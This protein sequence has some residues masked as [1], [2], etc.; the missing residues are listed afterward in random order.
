MSLIDFPMPPAEDRPAARYLLDHPD[1]VRRALGVQGQ[2]AAAIDPLTRAL[3]DTCDWAVLAGRHD[4]EAAHALVAI[5]EA[6]VA[7]DEA[8]LR[9]G[10]V[11]SAREV[12]IP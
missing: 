8:V 12:K 5:V 1:P 4:T 11:L 9:A 10:T 7:L 2:V 3:A 6:R